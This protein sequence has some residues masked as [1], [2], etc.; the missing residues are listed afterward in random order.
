MSTFGKPPVCSGVASLVRLALLLAFPGGLTQAL[1]L[2]T[3]FTVAF[4]SCLTL[5]CVVISVVVLVE[6]VVVVIVLVVVVFVVVVVVVVEVVV[7]VVVTMLFL[8]QV[9]LT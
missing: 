3:L 5:C 1:F 4:S 8:L 7:V 9:S 2:S 6:N